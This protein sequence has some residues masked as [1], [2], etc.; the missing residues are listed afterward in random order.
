MS[1]VLNSDLVRAI[2]GPILLIV[3]GSL[4]ALD[5]LG[6]V[7]FVRRTWPVLLIVFGV[8][9]LM[10]RSASAGRPAIAPPP[11]PEY[12]GYPPTYPPPPTGRPQ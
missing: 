5:N 8:L 6:G 4:V 2:R 1:S 7:S 10:E 12:P 3:L 11:Y 9:K